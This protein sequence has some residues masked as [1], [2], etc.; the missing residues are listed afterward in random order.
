MK[1]KIFYHIID[2]DRWNTI[3]DEQMG[4]I[5]DSGLIDNCELHANL[6]Y[7]PESYTEFK[8]KWK[9][10]NITWYNSP[11][12]PDEREHPTFILMQQN[13]LSTDENFY[14]L[15]LHVKGV[16][17]F[18]KWNANHVHNWRRYL[19]WFNIVNWRHMI[20]KLDEGIWDTVGVQRRIGPTTSKTKVTGYH[21]SGNSNWYTADFLRRCTPAL[22][23]PREVNYQA[24]VCDGGVH[25]AMDIEFYSGWH[26]ATGYSFFDTN[27]DHYREDCPE[28]LY[29]NFFDQ[30]Q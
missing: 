20:S 17:H 8:E 27:M 18:D 3:A 1:L 6:H 22:T 29:I 19:D 10:P 30:S 4:R 25:Y 23:L 11:D 28:S 14:C 9:H 12:M 13:A 24:Q 15:Y 21:Y 16:T 7:N 5:F 2:L 26:N